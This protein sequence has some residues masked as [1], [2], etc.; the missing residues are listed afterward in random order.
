MHSIQLIG[1]Q[2]PLSAK[3]SPHEIQIRDFHTKFRIGCCARECCVISRSAWWF[4]FHSAVRYRFK[5]LDLFPSH[6]FSRAKASKQKWQRMRRICALYMWFHYSQY[7]IREVFTLARKNGW[8]R[9]E[10]KKS[11]GGSFEWSGSLNAAAAH[12]AHCRVYSSPCIEPS[13]RCCAS[14]IIQNQASEGLIVCGLHV[15]AGFFSQCLRVGCSKLPSIMKWRQLLYNVVY[16][17]AV[18]RYY[19][20]SCYSKCLTC[21]FF[22]PL[23]IRCVSIHFYMLTPSLDPGKWGETTENRI[24]DGVNIFSFS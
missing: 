24:G 6:P 15:I 11:Y 7:L 3:K 18:P 20:S 1:M 19:N 2:I 13:M 16:R 21:V 8:K 14:R 17:L 10:E 23:F 9:R 12:H 5:I 4:L 22:Y